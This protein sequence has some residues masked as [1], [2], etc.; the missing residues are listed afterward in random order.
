[1]LRSNSKQS[2]ESMWKEPA[3]NVFDVFDERIFHDGE[4]NVY[5]LL[6]GC[7][8]IKRYFS[9]FVRHIGF[10]GRVLVPPTYLLVFVI[11]QNFIWFES[12]WKRL[13]TPQ[14]LRGW[15]IWLHMGNNFIT[16]IKR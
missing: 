1:M 10:V 5:V 8:A 15:I 4:F 12:A 16:A 14:I 3:F 11:V 13:L 9:I 6:V 7:N 2:A